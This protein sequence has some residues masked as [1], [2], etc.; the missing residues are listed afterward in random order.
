[1]PQKLRTLHLLESPV[2]EQVELSIPAQ[3][4]QIRR[5]SAWLELSARGQGVP[6]EQIQRLDIC[7]NEALAN[8]I[9]HSDAAGL[10]AP[11]SV[12]LE[13]SHIPGKHQAEVTVCD[14]CAAF[15]PLALYPKPRPKSL[16]EAEPG[17]LG[18]LMLRSFAD[19]VSYCHRDGQNRLSFSVRWPSLR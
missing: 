14:A 3:L 16:A 5:A 19:D 1:M 17:G 13:L 15:D 6:E 4:D 11:I 2:T 12:C 10:S 9:A 7:L 18:V 8:I